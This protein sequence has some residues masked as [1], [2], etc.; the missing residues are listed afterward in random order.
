MVSNSKR[1]SILPPSTTSSSH[2]KQELHDPQRPA[3]ATS[4]GFPHSPSGSRLPVGAPLSSQIKPT[5][6]HA[7]SNFSSSPSNPNMLVP[8]P[9][10]HLPHSAHQDMTRTRA[11]NRLSVADPLSTFPASR[12]TFRESLQ[13][14]SNVDIDPSAK[15]AK[16][17]SQYPVRSSAEPTNLINSV[18]E[19]PF[20]SRPNSMVVDPKRVVTGILESALPISSRPVPVDTQP[21]RSMSIAE[22]EQRHKA[23]LQKLQTHSATHAHKTSA[24][25]QPQ[26]QSPS[27]RPAANVKPETLGVLSNSKKVDKPVKPTDKSL[28]VSRRR[29]FFGFLNLK[30]S[31]KLDSAAE[32]TNKKNKNPSDK[33]QKGAS[34]DVPSQPEEEDEDVPLAQLLKT[35]RRASYNPP[36]RIESPNRK[37]FRSS[38]PNLPKSQSTSGVS[39][40]DLASRRMSTFAG[41]VGE[42]S[43]PEALN[44]SERPGHRRSSSYS[45][46]NSSRR[47]SKQFDPAASFEAI[48]EDPPLLLNNRHLSPHQFQPSPHHPQPSPYHFQPPPWLE[49]DSGSSSD[50]RVGPRPLIFEDEAKAIRS[51]RRLWT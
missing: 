16:R 8:P 41:V 12:N 7:L 11:N 3:S 50:Q 43:S 5:N 48:P 26:R 35:N 13:S 34:K 33:K 10:H 38:H 29:S 40:P 9:R 42:S 24:P 23:A 17:R 6:G 21:V 36:P 27:R 25:P 49:A 47:G 51:S 45:P 19:S 18:R 39:K 20:S 14:P 4:R 30:D 2:S 46:A 15:K 28:T 22:L 31:S 1:L 32:A 44:K 37:D